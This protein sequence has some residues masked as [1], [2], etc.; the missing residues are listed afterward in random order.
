MKRLAL[1]SVYDKKGLEQLGRGLAGLGFGLVASGGTARALQ[2]FGLEVQPVDA[3][4]G[5]PEVLG[6]RVKTLHPAVAGGI[7]ARRTPEHL[8]ELEQ[9]GIDP[10]DVVVC[11]LYPFSET[12][13]RAGVSEQEAIEEIDIGGVTLLRAA[14]KNSES[15]T[16]VCDPADYPA[17]LEALKEGEASLALRRRMA[18]KAFQHTAAYDAA[19]AGWLGGVVEEGD[20]LPE[21]LGLA[22]RRLQVMRYG[23]NPHQQAA[24]YAWAGQEPV[25]KQLSG[26][27]LSYNNL[28]DLDAAC[29][30][31]REFD[32]PTVAIIK[33]TNPCGLAS[34]ENL[35]EAYKMALDCD[36]I[37]AFGS[38]IATNRE[39]DMDLV[40][41][42]GKLFV[43]VLVAPSFSEKAAARLAKRKKKCR[44]VKAGQEG[45]G[46]PFM[47]SVRGGILVQQA[48][49][50]GVDPSTWTVATKRQPTEEER[51][52]LAFAWLAAKHVKSNA[53]VFAR[54]K[55]LV[56][57]GAGQMNRVDSVFLA[58]R[59]AGDK[60][61]GAVMGS[62]AFFPFPDG[63]ETAAEAGI[64]AIIQ[65]GGSIRDDQVI[66]AADRLGL[67]MVLTGERHFRH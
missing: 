19:I 31:P 50:R 62:D 32:E 29:S 45:E 2:E 1:I 55:A 66:E 51:G 4:T 5:F 28:V 43:E 8:A 3:L 23:E 42:I 18:L 11:N 59:R 64:T 7:L 36:P 39:V 16:V 22:A 40:K 54:G 63:V 12:V 24:L 26:K 57:V 15:V 33:H 13:A 9:H 21:F 10:I 37:S 14:A 56:G 6:G 30:I 48:D 65:P 46:A 38:I 34:A 35:V 60:A 67:A 25:F 17:V 52:S 49:V 27:E 20:E 47:R 58:A 44:V 53:I 61:R 41:A